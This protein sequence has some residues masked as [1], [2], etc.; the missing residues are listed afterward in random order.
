MVYDVNE[1]DT[2]FDMSMT[3]NGCEGIDGALNFGFFFSDPSSDEFVLE[4]FMD[5]ELREACTLRFDDWHYLTSFSIDEN[6][7]AYTGSTVF[8]GG[9]SGNCDG[10]R[11]SCSFDD[12]TITYDQEG[13]STDEELFTGNCR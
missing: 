3:F 5:G 4:Y 1:S 6:T 10:D 13:D 11:F 8:N 9:L 7:F 12:V 2:E